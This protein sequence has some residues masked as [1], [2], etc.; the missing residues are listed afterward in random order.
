MMVI[1]VT[2]GMASGKSTVARMIA[3][4]GI[5]HLN[6]DQMVHHLMKH[7]RELIADIA[8]AFPKAVSHNTIDRT[9]LA[10]T[11]AKKPELLETLETLIHPRVRAMEESAIAAAR[12]NRLRAVVL[13]VPL[14]F[15]TD[16]DALCDV[17]IVAH[18]PLPH[19]RRRAFARPGMNDEKWKRLLDRQLDDASR[20]A[21]ADIVLPTNI[22]KA[23]TRRII[24]ALMSEWG[25]RS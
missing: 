13:D 18:A 8:V 4:R 12:R 5:L 11:I 9:V 23:A 19:R 17:V 24:H 20:H 2:G 6:A 16:A 1:G 3:G 15:E 25:L 10:Q 14:L 21:R 7:D 22:G